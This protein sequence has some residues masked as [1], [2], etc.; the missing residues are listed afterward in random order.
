MLFQQFT[1]TSMVGDCDSDNEIDDPDFDEPAYAAF[2]LP[3]LTK[4]KR[5]ELIKKIEENPSTWLSSCRSWTNDFNRYLLHPIEQVSKV[6]HILFHIPTCKFN[7]HPQRY[8]ECLNHVQVMRAIP[9]K[10]YRQTGWLQAIKVIF[11]F[12]I[13]IIATYICA[14]GI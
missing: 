5:E 10:T 6:V 12:T 3:R 7:L 9:R 14:L 13:K 4:P 2:P 1:K 11:L 8:Q